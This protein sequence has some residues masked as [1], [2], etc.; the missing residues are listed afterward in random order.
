MCKCVCVCLSVCIQLDRPS[1]K[2]NNI[3][4]VCVT[5]SSNAYNKTPKLP[6]ETVNTKNENIAMVY[7]CILAL[8]RQ[9]N[10]IQLLLRTIFLYCPI[11]IN[12]NI[13]KFIQADFY[14]VEFIIIVAF[15]ALL[16]CLS[17]SLFT[18]LVYSFS[19]L[20]SKSMS[21][22]VVANGN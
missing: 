7:C 8:Q 6:L 14:K 13:D 12:D 9:S 3:L 2:R 10:N 18:S 4:I 22:N 1:S 11:A 16:L 19:L 20:L 15:F 5:S 21:K 17:L